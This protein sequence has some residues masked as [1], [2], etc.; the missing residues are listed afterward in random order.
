MKINFSQHG[1]VVNTV[2]TMGLLDNG[3]LILVP[4][5][6]S[7]NAGGSIFGSSSSGGAG[8]GQ[9]SPGSCLRLCVEVAQGCPA[10][11]AEQSVKEH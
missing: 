11:G 3:N 7:A 6:S 2:I 8:M 1:S 4:E 9:Q 5:Q 10:A